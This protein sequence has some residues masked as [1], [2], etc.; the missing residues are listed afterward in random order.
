[1]A[2]FRATLQ[3]TRGEASRLGDKRNGLTAKVNG[4]NSGVRVEAEVI[5]GHD[6]FNIYATGGSRARFS[7]Q[8]VGCVEIVNGEPVFTAKAV[9]P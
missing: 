5:D 9:T 1:M 8:Y 2:Q 7:G 4:W 6:V 3:G